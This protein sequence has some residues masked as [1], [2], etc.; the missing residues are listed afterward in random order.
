[1]V[2]AVIC[3]TIFHFVGFQWGKLLSD[4]SLLQSFLFLIFSLTLAL[5][6][7]VILIIKITAICN[8][9]CSTTKGRSDLTASQRKEIAPK[10]LNQQLDLLDSKLL[11]LEENLQKSENRVMRNEEEIVEI[12]RK[13][14]ARDLREHSCQELF[15]AN[16]ILSGVAAQ[17]LEG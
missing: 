3:R 11:R 17:A 12:E 14:I 16:M 15:A 1:M 6:A 2:V 10:E 13:R 9:S 4:L 5:T 8:G 7:L